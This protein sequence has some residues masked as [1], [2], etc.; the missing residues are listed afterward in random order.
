MY[1]PFYKL[2]ILGNSTVLYFLVVKNF[3]AANDDQL[4]LS[5]IILQTIHFFLQNLVKFQLY[6]G[7]GGGYDRSGPRLTLAVETLLLSAT[8]S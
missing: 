5:F 8:G 7:T 6:L 4:R 3:I 1:I 2:C